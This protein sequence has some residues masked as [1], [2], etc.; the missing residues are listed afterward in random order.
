MQGV[1]RHPYRYD[2]GSDQELAVGLTH[3]AKPVA[4]LRAK[5]PRLGLLLLLPSSYSVL[6]NHPPARPHAVF[7]DVSTDRQGRTMSAPGTACPC[8]AASTAAG[9]RRTGR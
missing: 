1:T 3:H 5:A 8:T 4:T 6:R 9:W 2:C 7:A